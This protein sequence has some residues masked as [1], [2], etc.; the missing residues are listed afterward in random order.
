MQTRLDV[1]MELA[2][3][4]QMVI[5]N[6]EFLFWITGNKAALM[7]ALTLSRNVFKS[8]FMPPFEEEEVYCFALVGRW[9]GPSVVG[10]VGP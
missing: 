2:E 3:L 7:P 5:W 10:S 6:I 1:G 9:V 4:W 8:I